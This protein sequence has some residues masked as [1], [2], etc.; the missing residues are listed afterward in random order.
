MPL[1]GGGRTSKSDPCIRSRHLTSACPELVRRLQIRTTCNQ[2]SAKINISQ[3]ESDQLTPA[4]A[5]ESG[6]DH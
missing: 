4:Q 3:A 2:P 5:R 6:E 1:G